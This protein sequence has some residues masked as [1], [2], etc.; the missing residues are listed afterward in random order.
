M[1]GKHILSGT[2]TLQHLPC[3]QL[4]VCQIAGLLAK[5][6]NVVY[7]YMHVTSSFCT[8]GPQ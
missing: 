6:S 8:V 2:R 3:V 7:P 5:E 4:T 1:Q